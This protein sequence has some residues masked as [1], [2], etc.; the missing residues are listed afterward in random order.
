MRLRRLR[1]LGLRATRRWR[2][3]PVDPYERIVAAV[4][5]RPET[6]IPRV[7]HQIWLG[8]E[9][10]PRYTMES[11]RRATPDWLHV[12]WTDDN[13]PPMTNRAVFDAFESAYHAKADILRYEVLYRFGGVYVDADQLCLRSLDDLLGPDVAF[14]A[15]YQN[16]G[17]PELDDELRRAPLIANGVIGAA[18]GHPIL[19]RVI[20]D[21][22]ARAGSN[23]LPWITVGPAALTR[24]IEAT[25]VR[26]VVHPFHAFYPYH[27][28]EFIPADPQE[29]LKAIHYRS[30]CVS[31]WGTTLD[32]YARCRRAAGR[33][34]SVTPSTGTSREFAASHPTLAATVYH[35]RPPDAP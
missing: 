22:C 15:G 11:C 4:A 7:V 34:L 25:P 8:P 26:A 9:P 1:T 31:L 33:S 12:V 23:E 28:T 13:L 24:A 20:A 16:L 21:V 35:G 18:P 2:A 6:P 29:M 19:E 30:H 10:P 3:L 17:N 14:F 5:G 27:Y 32:S